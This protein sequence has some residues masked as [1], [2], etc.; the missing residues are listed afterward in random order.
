MKKNQ[1]QTYDFK[2]TEQKTHT[3]IY[4]CMFVSKLFIKLYQFVPFL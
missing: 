3:H 4:T 1:V 2:M